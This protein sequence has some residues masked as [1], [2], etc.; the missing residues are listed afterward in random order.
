MHKNI[1]KNIN[2]INILIF[3]YINLFK[4]YSNAKIFQIY[5]LK[6]FT[7]MDVSY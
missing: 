1:K 6:N 2:N 5:L 3:F 7:R 4:L